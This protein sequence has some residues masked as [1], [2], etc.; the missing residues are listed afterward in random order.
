LIPAQLNDLAAHR[1]ETDT[2]LRQNY[3]GALRDLLEMARAYVLAGV[4]PVDMFDGRRLPGK[5]GND[6][7]RMERRLAAHAAV[8]ATLSGLSDTETASLQA[9]LDR[10]GELGIQI[11]EKTMKAAVAVN[12]ELVT[13]AIRQL[14]SAGYT[15][16][17]APYEADAQLAALGLRRWWLEAPARIRR[18]AERREGLVHG[19][20]RPRSGPGSSDGA[21]A[22]PQHS[23]VTLLV[24]SENDGRSAQPLPRPDGRSDRRAGR[25]AL[26]S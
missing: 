11:D 1:C 16:I 23:G 20:G 2:V 5:G 15:V 4:K 14:R 22:R 10:G 9:A 13:A 21:A 24:A 6:E 8:Q 19:P 12:D 18:P 17:K 25:S 7:V 3:D 26:L